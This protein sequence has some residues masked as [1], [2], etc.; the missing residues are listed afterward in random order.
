MNSQTWLASVTGH[1][2]KI[3]VECSVVQTMKYFGIW[4][5]EQELL[6]AKRL[7]IFFVGS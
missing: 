4:G 3:R 7:I 2:L 6:G 5:L 1:L